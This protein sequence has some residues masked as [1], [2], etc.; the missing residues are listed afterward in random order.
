[1]ANHLLT[2]RELEVLA[3]MAKGYSNTQICNELFITQATVLTHICRLYQKLE[4]SEY[5]GHGGAAYRVRAV[6]KYF[7]LQKQGVVC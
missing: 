1:M 5:K 7:E 6:L 2:N 4:I 3:L